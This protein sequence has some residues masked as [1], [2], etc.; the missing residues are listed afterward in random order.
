M[1]VPVNI[2]SILCDM[3]TGMLFTIMSVNNLKF[4]SVGGLLSFVF[5]FLLNNGY[6]M[7]RVKS[8]S[9]SGN[10][11]KDQGISSVPSTNKDA[12]SL[13]CLPV[14]VDSEDVCDQRQEVKVADIGRRV[15]EK[16]NFSYNSTAE[17]SKQP[18]AV[19][20]SYPLNGRE[21]KGVASGSMD[22]ER[23]EMKIS[24]GDSTIEKTYSYSQNSVE[25]EEK[26]QKVSPPRRKVSR[27]EKSEKLGNWLRKDRN[28]PDF[29]ATSTRQQ[30]T[31][32]YS[33]NNVGPQRYDPELLPDGNINEILEVGYLCSPVFMAIFLLY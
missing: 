11:R 33:T 1:L 17:F 5:G 4:V 31:S 12:L 21:E 28:G 23:H 20:S 19:S 6:S 22:R 32:I 26:V 25:T 10:A 27:E 18:S 24:Y 7:N 9:R 29:S 15:V 16:E 2:R 14:S 3:Q 30:N 13:S 8:L